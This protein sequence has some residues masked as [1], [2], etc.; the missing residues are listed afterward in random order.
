MN[1]AEIINPTL[2]KPK[3]DYSLTSEGINHV[4]ANYSKERLTP[5]IPT[6]P[7]SMAK[8]LYEH[9]KLAQLEI[10]FL[11]SERSKITHLAK[12]CP[13]EAGEFITW[14]ESL[15]QHG[16]GQYD[17]LFKWLAE[18]A[19]YEQM[20]WFIRQEVV[21]E[22]GFDDLISL[23]QLRMPT[24]PK[25]EMSRNLWDEMGAGKE[26]GMHG[27]MLGVLAEDLKIHEIDDVVWEAQALGN[28]MVGLAANRCFAYQSVGC[29]GAVELTAPSRCVEVVKGLERLGVSGEAAVYYRLH[30]LIDIR[31][32]EDWNKEV[33]YNLVDEDPARAIHIAEGALMRLNAGARTFDRYRKHYGL[34]ST[35]AHID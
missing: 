16:P 19:S 7:S 21:G 18:D 3:C 5:S 15:K 31:H 26:K 28:V 22:A 12:Q 33:I 2:N 10:D 34:E 11:N 8:K 17:S 6:D 27:P 30:A 13:K 25:L 35:Q 1:N 32:S 4:L 9:A 24:R 23:T 20:R 29:L 14:F